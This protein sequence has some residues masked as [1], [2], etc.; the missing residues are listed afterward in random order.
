MKYNYL[1]L[2]CI[3]FIICYPSGFPGAQEL[4]PPVWSVGDWW[5]VK[6]QVYD[7]GKIVAGSKPRWLPPQTWRFYVEKQDF[8]DSQP[9][10]VV[11]IRPVEDNSYPYWFRYW[12]RV[13]DRYVGRYELYHP[14]T[15]SGTKTRDIGPA[16]VR[17]KFDPNRTVPFLTSKFP[18]VPITIPL[19][20][21]D[22]ESTSAVVREKTIRS[23]TSAYTNPEFEIIQ[24]IQEVDTRTLSEKA[25]P[26]FLKTIGTIS[27][28]GNTFIT[29]RTKS[30]LQEEQHWD[31][32]L[33]WCVYGQRVENAVIFKRYWLVEV[34]KD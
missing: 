27:K 7:S 21:V 20:A 4:H 25:N 33:P 26:D 24:E 8:I 3:V 14:D 28:D 6:S 22:R 17:K 31:P 12:F 19:F 13:S 1:C 32:Q 11:I 30:S 18:T 23:E 2:F 10:F 5:I 16:V 34:G 9:Y 15:S 29:I